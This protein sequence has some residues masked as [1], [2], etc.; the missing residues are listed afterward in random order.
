ML[1][2]RTTELQKSLVK[3]K[4]DA[5]LVSSAVNI[6]YLTGYPNFS[7]DEREAYLL[8]CSNAAT[9]FTDP[10]Y[11]EAVKKTISKEINATI[12]KPSKILKETLAKNKV[13]RLGIENNLTIQEYDRFKKFLDIKLV[14]TDDLVEDLRMVKDT[15]EIKSLKKAAALTDKTYSHVLENMRVGID[16]TEK[17]LAW[18]MEKFIKENG[19]TLAF[20]TIVAFGPNSSVPHHITS[21]KKLSEKDEFILLDFGAKVNGYCADMTRTRLTKSSS[22]KANKIYEAVFEAQKKAAESVIAYKENN[23]AKAGEIA[24]EVLVSK[25]FKPVP[26]GLGHGIGL[27]VHEFPH[28]WPQSDD[29]LIEGNYFSIEPGIYIPGFGG[30]RIEDDYLMTGES[31][32]Q[33]TESPKDILE[34]RC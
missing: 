33:I 18:K 9:L 14:R 5:I 16:I 15:D 28:L 27:E 17:E 8:V 1:R 19:G 22:A 30:V 4:I 23:A 10:R 3:N 31:L 12:E 32:Q 34:I 7:K 11:I 29:V 25:G 26:H 2:D 20:D 24:N 6:H 21:D 13:K